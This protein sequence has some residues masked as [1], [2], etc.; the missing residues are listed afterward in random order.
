MLSHI[1]CK[2]AFI[3]QYITQH[4]INLLSIKHTEYN[5]ACIKFN[6]DNESISPQKHVYVYGYILHLQKDNMPHEVYIGL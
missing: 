5:K 2:L 4:N 1:M 6:K 3:V